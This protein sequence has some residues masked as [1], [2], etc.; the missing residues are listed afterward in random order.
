VE[1][2]RQF[3]E[4]SVNPFS[5][6][7]IQEFVKAR[8]DER[9][10]IKYYASSQS[11]LAEAESLLPPFYGPPCIVVFICS[12]LYRPTFDTRCIADV[13]SRLVFGHAGVRWRNGWTNYVALSTGVSLGRRH[14]VFDS[15][16]EEPCTNVETLG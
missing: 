6:Y 15:G 14:V 12:V 9:P 3:A 4:K 10:G 2:L 8:T 16:R 11:I 5:K 1:H 7:R 13:V